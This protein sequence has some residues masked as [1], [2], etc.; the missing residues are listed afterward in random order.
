MLGKEVASLVNGELQNAGYYNITWNAK[1]MASGIYYY[2]IK[3]GDFV[4][5]KKMMLVK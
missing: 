5:A 4:S 1:N 2:Q 3:A